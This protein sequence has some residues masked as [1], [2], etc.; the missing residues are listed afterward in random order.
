MPRFVRIDMEEHLQH[1]VFGGYPS[2][3]HVFIHFS[4]SSTF[5]ALLDFCVDM[6]QITSSLAVFHVLDRIT[7]HSC[8]LILMHLSL[9]VKVPRR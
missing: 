9:F 3:N 6:F 4:S 8:N 1:S 2:L 5:F 7:L